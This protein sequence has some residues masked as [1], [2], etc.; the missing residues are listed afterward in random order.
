MPT[1][2]ELESRIIDYIDNGQRMVREAI[3]ALER[4]T[5]KKAV[6]QVENVSGFSG[7]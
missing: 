6:G 4:E 7:V 2:E 5:I 3:I 1:E